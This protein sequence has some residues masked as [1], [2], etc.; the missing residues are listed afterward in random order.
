MSHYTKIRTQLRERPLIL[1]ALQ[2]MGFQHVENHEIA[3]PLY[4]YQGD[5]RPECAEI[6]I[7]RQEVGRLSN[8]VGFRQEET[9]EFEAIIS[10]FDRGSGKCSGTFLQDL[11]RKY[12]YGVVKEQMHE[13]NWILEQETTYENGD[14]V[15]ILAERG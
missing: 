1:R 3:Q 13:Q 15:I 12:A 7:R 14:V 5:K 11:H 10:E 2:E 8:D 9:G 6:I 4:G